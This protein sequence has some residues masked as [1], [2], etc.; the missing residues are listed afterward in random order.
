LH[1]ALPLLRLAERVVLLRG[2]RRTPFS[3]MLEP[4][5]FDPGDHLDRHGMR[6]EECML[7]RPDEQG[8]EEIL[9]LVT[10]M[11]ADLLVMG[12]FGRSRFSEWV[13]GGATRHVLREA[14]IPV[15]LRH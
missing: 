2:Q 12:G 9:E 10:T 8:G 4:P 3:P 7:E 5:A 6:Y 15:L 14:G 11:R 1:A 13:L